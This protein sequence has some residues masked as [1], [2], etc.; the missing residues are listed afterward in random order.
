[1]SK[2]QLDLSSFKVQ[3][4][5]LLNQTERKTE[6][7]KKVDSIIEQMDSVKRGGQQKTIQ[8]GRPPK[9]KAEKES[10]PITLKFTEQ[11]YKNIVAVAGDVPLATYLKRQLLDNGLI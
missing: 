6:V 8:V 7:E 3:N 5:K 1:M 10:K 2:K 9:A 11:Q 4:K